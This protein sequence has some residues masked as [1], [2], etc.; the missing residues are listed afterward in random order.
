MPDPN[1]QGWMGLEELR[2][3][4]DTAHGMESIVEIGSWKGRST[5]ALCSGSPG[6]VCAVDHFSGSSTERESNHREAKDRDI[7]QDFWANCGHFR[8]LSIL[9]ME[10]TCAARL[11]KP[12]SIDMVFI[13][14]GHTFDEVTADIQA[15]RGI[16]KKLLCGHDIHYSEVKGAIE[17]QGL[18]PQHALDAIWYV[19]E[20]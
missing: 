14:G 2:W 13:D 19:K 8:N 4:Y 16:C 6:F 5:H 17:N 9:R 10:S 12:K 3:L 1:I 20:F 11:F 18:Q 15:W 7:A